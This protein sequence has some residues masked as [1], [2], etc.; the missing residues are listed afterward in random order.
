MIV[1]CHI[2]QFPRTQSDNSTRLS[3]IMIPYMK[4]TEACCKWHQSALNCTTQVTLCQ[5]QHQ[6]ANHIVYFRFCTSCGRRKQQWNERTVIGHLLQSA[7]LHM[8]KMSF[9]FHFCGK[10]TEWFSSSFHRLDALVF[11]LKTWTR[12][13]QPF[14]SLVG[15]FLLSAAPL[16]CLFRSAAS[17]N[18]S[19]HCSITLPTGK[20]EWF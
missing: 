2:F 17:L 13:K 5:F 7:A 10:Y 3:A 9:S 1:L 16:M 14:P 20:F 8:E 18:H 6:T 12:R 4:S 19:R 11:R 15:H